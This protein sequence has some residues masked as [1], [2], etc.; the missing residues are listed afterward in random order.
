[1]SL[2]SNTALILCTCTIACVIIRMIIPEG[3][4]RKTINLIITAFLIIVM[5][6]PI[7]NLFTK[8]ETFPLSTPDEAEITSEYN[9]KVIAL[10]KENIRNSLIAL[11]KQNDI[12]AENVYVDIKTD[13]T[14][15]IFINYIYIYLSESNI[16]N[17]AKAIKITEE[18]FNITPEIILS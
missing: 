9:D 7:K 14:S 11:L 10:T 5:I 16:N 12:V 6:A 15:G 17:S 4:T 3:R 18:N 1:M 2:I 8:S 13:K